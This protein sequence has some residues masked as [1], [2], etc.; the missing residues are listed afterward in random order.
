MK[1]LR[2]GIEQLKQAKAHMSKAN[3]IMSNCISKLKALEEENAELRAELDDWKG[4]AEGFQPD[5]YMRLPLDADGIA[6]RPGDKI[7]FNGDPDS[8]TLK[9]IA[10]GCS[11]YPVEFVDWEETGTTAW[12]EGS[13][14]THRQPNPEQADSWEKLEEDARK[15]A[16]NYALA[17][18]DEDG[19][20]TCNGCRFQESE[21]C[22]HEMVLDVFERA[23]KLAG[24]EE[25]AQ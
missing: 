17:P 23:K 4:N 9:C 18:R 6:I 19:L 8:E 15:T 7:Y 22:H 10:V 5:A 20:T 2:S 25:E 13:A 1:D 11:P 12:E 3:G 21:S 16:C 24:I 14:F